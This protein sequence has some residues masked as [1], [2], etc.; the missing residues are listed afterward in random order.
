MAPW[1][2]A[3]WRSSATL[4]EFAIFAQSMSQNVIVGGD[5]RKLLNAL[6]HVDERTL[7][8][9]VPFRPGTKGL[10]LI[11]AFAQATA[12]TLPAEH[13]MAAADWFKVELEELKASLATGTTLARQLSILGN[14]PV[15][16]KV[17]GC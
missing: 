13:A 1:N 7:A 5:F 2:F 11:E 4:G 8:E 9:C 16:A 17:A 6:S 14:P 12:K 3:S 15:E 10:H